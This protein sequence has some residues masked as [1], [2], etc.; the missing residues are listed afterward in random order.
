MTS[1]AIEDSDP[2]HRGH[3]PRSDPAH[4]ASLA[5]LETPGLHL[6]IPILCVVEVVYF[7]SRYRLESRFLRGLEGF[8]V[9]APFSPGL[10]SDRRS[11]R[12]VRGL[13]A[14]RCRRLRD[15][16]GRTVLVRL[17]HHCSRPAGRSRRGK[18]YANISDRQQ[19]FGACAGRAPSHK[20]RTG[21][22]LLVTDA[23]PYRREG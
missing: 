18:P 14:R 20:G 4:P 11:C 16:P 13:S 3:Q 6:V 1:T 2:P 8:D 19:S 7:L 17:D 5:A 15:R 12:S 9:Q 23:L 21:C 22:R 10:V